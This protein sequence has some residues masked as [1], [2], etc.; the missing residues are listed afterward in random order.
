MSV[1]GPGFA[2][3]DAGTLIFPTSWIR[4]AIEIALTF[5]SLSPSSFAIA[6]DSFA[7]LT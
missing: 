1:R 4:E 5:S 6:T 3:I 7:T 2:S